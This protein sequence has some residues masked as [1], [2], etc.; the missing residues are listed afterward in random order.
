[1]QS[2]VSGRTALVGIGETGYLRDSGRL[3]DDLLIDACSRAI[4]DAGLRP[5]DIDAIIPPPGFISAEELG[6]HLGIP[7]LRYS[8]TVHLGGAS[9]VAAL[10]TA[11]MAIATGL[12]STVLIVAGWNG[13]SA[14]RPRPGAIRPRVRKDNGVLVSQTPDFYVPYGLRT[15]AQV[16][17]LFLTRYKALYGISDD[18]AATIAL[19]T[20]R[21]ANRNSLALMKDVQLTRE[22]YDAA[23]RIAGP[24]RKF[25]CCLETDCAAAVVLTGIDRARDLPHRPV[26]YLGGA[27]GHPYPGD[28]IASRDD[29][30]RIGLQ[31]AAPQALAMA[32]I[33]ARDADFLQIY[34]CFTYVVLMQLEALG[35]AEP[36]GAGK[37]VENGAIDIGGRYPVNTHGG[38]LSQGHA[39]GMNH[40]A[41]A[42]K[43]LRGKADSQVTGASLGIV[44]GFGDLADGSIAVLGVGD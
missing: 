8:A 7:G 33:E 27:Q 24:L 28:E 14:L 11:A 38:L 26:L 41:E 15:P 1:M 10:L 43:Q 12:A 35:L 3:P 4:A 36:G 44:T 31:T 25:D 2:S 13:Y 22:E 23:A 34:D 40:V 18:A 30:M 19:T 21:H 6:A 17:S 39:W 32:G 5:A 9:P 42:V 20:R 37:F 29:V 16:Y